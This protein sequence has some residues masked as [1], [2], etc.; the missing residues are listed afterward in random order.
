MTIH[1]QRASAC[2]A[3]QPRSGEAAPARWRV[4][5]SH[6]TA[7]T[8]GASTTNT[9][10]RDWGN[11]E[12]VGLEVDRA[13]LL[14]GTPGGPRPLFNRQVETKNPGECSGARGLV[15]QDVWLRR[16]WRAGRSHA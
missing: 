11:G 8:A 4:P 15:F 6:N 14:V 1:S 5:P 2:A 10:H 3:Y 13:S 12:R 9:A 16:S 7:S